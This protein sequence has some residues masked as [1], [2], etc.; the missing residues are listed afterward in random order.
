MISLRID[1]AANA[2]AEKWGAKNPDWIAVM[3]SVLKQPKLTNDR[4]S[5][6]LGITA[7]SVPLAIEAVMKLAPPGACTAK[8]SLGLTGARSSVSERWFHSNSDEHYRSTKLRPLHDRAGRTL[9]DC[10]P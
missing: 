3:K 4:R 2:P 6:E 5:V 1:A 7:N 10:A 8:A 9:L